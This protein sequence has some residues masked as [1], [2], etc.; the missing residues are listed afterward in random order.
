MLSVRA[1]PEFVRY[2]IVCQILYCYLD[3]ICSI[4]DVSY[5][6]GVIGPILSIR[7]GPLKVIK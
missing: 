1:C 5:Y 3:L 6:F 7:K 2:I 4:I